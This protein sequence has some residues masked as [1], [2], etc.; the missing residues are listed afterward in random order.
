MVLNCL[1]QK[2][3]RIKLKSRICFD[4]IITEYHSKFFY[5]FIKNKLKRGLLNKLKIKEKGFMIG[6]FSFPKDKIETI[7]SCQ[8]IRDI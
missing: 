5:R 7:L 1:I 6:L 4:P 3:K 8:F 2:L